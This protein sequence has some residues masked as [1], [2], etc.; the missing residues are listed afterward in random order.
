MKK[1]IR[2]VIHKKKLTP[3]EELFCRYFANNRDCFGNGTLAY[4]K[5]F[6]TKQNPVKYESAK[7]NAAR[8]LTND[9]LLKRCRELLDIRYS[10]EVIDK[11]LGAVALQWADMSA[12]VGAIREFNRVKGRIEIRKKITYDP[13]DTL[14]DEEIENAEESIRRREKALA[15]KEGEIAD[16]E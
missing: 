11:E 14:T 6:N 4:L 9:N 3:K 2:Q 13:K 1:D 5:A 15:E 12:K 7:A 8:L 10:E 16:K